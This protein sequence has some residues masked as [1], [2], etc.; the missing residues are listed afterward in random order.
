MLC[1]LVCLV[2]T[3]DDGETKLHRRVANAEAAKRY[4]QKKKNETMEIPSSTVDT[5]KQATPKQVQGEEAGDAKAGTPDTEAAKRHTETEKKMKTK[6]KIPAEE[7]EKKCKFVSFEGVAGA[8]L[9][10]GRARRA[11]GVGE[12][13]PGG[14]G[15]G[16]RP[17]GPQI[18]HPPPLLPKPSKP[19]SFA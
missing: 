13:G 9:I 16:I 3:M 17:R 10:A 6:E 19:L 15:R 2:V 4:R 12:S 14:R 18:M 5:N 11:Q 7:E 8:I 1:L